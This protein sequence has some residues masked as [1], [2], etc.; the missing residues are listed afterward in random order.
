MVIMV[1]ERRT[2]VG[3]SL[4]TAW[5]RVSFDKCHSVGFYKLE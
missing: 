3:S 1:S 2:V 4:V 5:P